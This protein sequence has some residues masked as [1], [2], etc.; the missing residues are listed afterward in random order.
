MTNTTSNRPYEMVEAPAFVLHRATK[1]DIAWMVARRA[2]RTLAYGGI[3]A[4][5]LKELAKRLPPPYTPV[6]EILGAALAV[7]ID[8]GAREVVRSRTGSD[9]DWPVHIVTK[10]R[11]LSRAKGEAGMKPINYLVI[12]DLLFTLVVTLWPDFPKSE[13]MIA[14]P[15]ALTVILYLIHKFKPA[16]IGT[17]VF[18]LLLASALVALCPLDVAS[19]AKAYPLGT[20]GFAFDMT[21][22]IPLAQAR[23]STEPGTVV[24]VQPLIAFGGGLTTYWTDKNDPEQVKIV[25]FNFPILALSVRGADA[26]KLDL[27]VIADLGFFDNK[28]RFGG[29][30]YCGPKT[31]EQSRFIAV[32]SIG[33]NVFN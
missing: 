27:T 4:T 16:K 22:E 18:V 29:G 21:M 8:K 31:D 30:Y 1:R 25:S 17:G 7:G 33:T 24:D 9:V 23:E 11:E 12:A 32:F 15:N 28:I 6:L 3:G 10:L 13:A 5:L 19:Q 14:I 20:K 2:F 26:T